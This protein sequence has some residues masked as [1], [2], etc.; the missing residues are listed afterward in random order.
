M[1][2]PDIGDFLGLAEPISEYRQYRIPKAYLHRF[3]RLKKFPDRLLVLGD[4]VCKLNPIYGQGM[5][6]TAKEGYFLWE[7]LSRVRESGSDLSG[8][9]DQFRREMGNVGA[10]WAWQL[11]SGSDLAYPQARGERPFNLNFINWYVKRL[12][13]SAETKLEV[14]KALMDAMAL[15]KPP[16]SIMR[17]RLILRAL[18]L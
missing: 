1:D 5:T 12:F 9:S 14:R 2:E 11:T 17:P 3:D 18:G 15:V 10:N 16:E 7:S 6:K 8:F 4:A 13:A